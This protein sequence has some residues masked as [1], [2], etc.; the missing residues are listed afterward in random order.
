MFEEL[1]NYKVEPVMA[2]K[3]TDVTAALGDDIFSD[4]VVTDRHDVKSFVKVM[5]A[6]YQKT[7]KAIKN[8]EKA[9]DKFA[10]THLAIVQAPAFDA[11]LAMAFYEQQTTLNEA[12]KE[13]ELWNA[14]AY[15]A[16]KKLADQTV[17]DFPTNHD[18]L[19]DLSDKF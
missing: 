15:Y 7:A 16:M 10:Q 8:Y 1:K 13:A 4:I 12:A 17:I 14:Y 5:R 11:K 2:L 6:I 3:E 18:K 9:E 19:S